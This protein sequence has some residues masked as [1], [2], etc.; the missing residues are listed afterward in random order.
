M[1]TGFP[2]GDRSRASKIEV[3]GPELPPSPRRSS[4]DKQLS[5]PRARDDEREQ[6]AKTIAALQDQ[7]ANLNAENRDL[8]LHCENFADKIKKREDEISR[9]GRVSVASINND[10]VTARKLR[11]LEKNF[12]T[13]AQQDASNLQIEQLTNQ[14]DFLTDQ[15][16]KYEER[17]RDATQQLERNSGLSQKLEYVAHFAFLPLRYRLPQLI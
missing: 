9:L 8:Q 6:H 11:D 16:V 10:A 4:L 5:S 14:V 2:P 17:L 12:E 3:N 13:Q 1:A 7:I 15:V